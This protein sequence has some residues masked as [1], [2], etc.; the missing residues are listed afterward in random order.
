MIKKYLSKVIFVFSLCSI[1]G[2]FNFHQL[3]AQVTGPY[4][5]KWLWVG[6]L[7]HWFSDVGA[8]I[9]YGRRGRGPSTTNT[10]QNDGLRWPAQFQFQDHECGK[11]LWI[12]TTDFVDP[13]SGKPF[14]YKVVC[15]G[16]GALYSN[17]EIFPVAGKFK[18][19]GRASSP[20]VIVD[21]V[22]ASDLDLNDLN[23]ASGDE[24]DSNLPADR[25]IRT[26]V[27]TPI[28]ITVYRR[29]FA[30]SQQYHD[31]Y[32]IYEYIFKNTGYIDNKGTKINPPDTLT[33][34]VF[35]FQNRLADGND[36]Y[37]GGWGH[38]GTSWGINTINDCVGQDVTRTLPSPNNFRAVFSYYGPH[39]EAPGVLDDIGYP[40]FINGSIMG[41]T[42][43]VG[44]VVLH[45]DTSPN[46]TTDDPTQPKTTRFMGSD[47]DAQGVNELS[48][49]NLDLMTRKYAFMTAG[50]PQ[51]HANQLGKDINGWPTRTANNWVGPN[52]ADRGGF[53]SAQGFGPY[54]LNP[55]DS[56]RI[57]I[58]EAV[59]G[60]NR[61]KNKEIMRNWW[62]WY[63]AGR[64]GG[65]PYTL[66]DGSTTP[67]GNVY[68]NT[69]VF[70]GKDSLF[71]SFRRA[72]A[73]YHL[74]LHGNHIP[75]PP[76]PPDKFVVTSGGNKIMLSWVGT[77]AELWPNFDGYRI[78]RGE[79]R[80]DTT[81]DQIFS[82]DKS[83]L[84]N[85]FD[86]RTAWIQLFLLYTD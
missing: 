20:I 23:L 62:P 59:A 72:L 54:D 12:G 70:T 41:G 10:D 55:E 19:I 82:C 43:F 26:E 66:P 1:L 61:D 36:G 35:H 49:T 33:G 40:C 65:G 31:N 15:F 67:D 75:E 85:S 83:N 7:R 42:H 57:V 60:I 30:Y 81:Y 56:I 37:R 79:G 2:I 22:S 84:V 45:A 38:D 51:T 8:E 18:L 52:G 4:E 63:Q 11:A 29:I 64:T 69:W 77:T 44:E 28:G 58:A 50:H 48:P 5:I 76:P 21:D 17:T 47:N 46:D 3:H 24:L 14:P 80:Q 78:Y 71:Q 73:N 6:S 86:D 74:Q 16:R 32:F 39:S 34:V 9:E 27:N 68:K 25:M 13:N 53:S